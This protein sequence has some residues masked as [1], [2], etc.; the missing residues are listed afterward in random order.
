MKFRKKRLVRVGLAI[1]AVSIALF[2][3]RM[4]V[5]Y[6]LQFGI[7]NTVTDLSHKMTK[8]EYLYIVYFIF[9]FDALFS[10]L[11]VAGIA[12]R[13]IRY[14]H[15][16]IGFSSAII[17]VIT[18]WIAVRNSVTNLPIGFVLESFLFLIIMPTFMWMFRR[19]DAQDPKR[20]G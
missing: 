17:V 19:R 1:I 6:I 2:F 20:L 10:C 9:M 16:A 13:F 11:I 18:Y 7:E 4:G 3:V 14:N 12:A 8:L 5:F 15:V